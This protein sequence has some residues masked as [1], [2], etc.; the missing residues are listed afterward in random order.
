MNRKQLLLLKVME[1]CDELSQRAS[2]A[3][4]FGLH[5]I[6]DHVGENPNEATNLERLAAE[7]KDLFVSLQMVLAEENS[8]ASMLLTET[9]IIKREER[10]HKYMEYSRQLGLLTD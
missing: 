3:I 9:D 2:K 8:V 6:Q 5:E 10:I 7:Y 1:E 4:R